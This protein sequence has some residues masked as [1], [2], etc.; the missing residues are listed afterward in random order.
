MKNFVILIFLLFGNTNSTIWGP[1][2]HRVV[3]E[4]AEQNISKKTKEMINK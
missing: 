2:G 3:G 4:I 1:T